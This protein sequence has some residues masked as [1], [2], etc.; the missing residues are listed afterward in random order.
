MTEH[1]QWTI[2]P[3]VKVLCR[4]CTAE[5]CKHIGIPIDEPKTWE[6]WQRIRHYVAHENVRVY[7][8]SEDDWVV[9][10][11]TKCGQLNGNKCMAWNTPDYPSICT[12]YEMTTCVMNEEGDWW[13]IMFTIPGDVD[14]HMV[15]LGLTGA[16][17]V[18]LGPCVSVPVDDLEDLKDFD[19]IRWYLAHR[20][21]MAYRKGSRWLV[22]L[23]AMCKDCD[24]N[25]SHIPKE[26]EYDLALKNWDDVKR[27][28]I[29]NKV[30]QPKKPQG[31]AGLKFI[32]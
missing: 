24:A 4:D 13:Q 10:F 20:D 21:V 16:P 32:G 27:Y 31:K 30:P 5:C 29:E 12:E 15:K 25:N 2:D 8:D 18:P 7:L 19:D 14:A 23:N 6:D 1:P 11:T 17:V 22:H 9:E 26:S 3:G 28:C